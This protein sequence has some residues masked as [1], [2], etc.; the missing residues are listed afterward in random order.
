MA[1]WAPPPSQG[2]WA[3]IGV[4]YSPESLTQA[5][6]EEAGRKLEAAKAPTAKL[7]T[8]FG[9]DGELAVFEV[10]ETQEAYDA[11][12][13]I[14]FPILEE[15]GIKFARPADIVPIVSLYTT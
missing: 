15:V 7:H 8:C 6:Y 2:E 13:P 11:H 14:L 1:R 5:Q 12:T 4:Y 9:K 10:W 3:M